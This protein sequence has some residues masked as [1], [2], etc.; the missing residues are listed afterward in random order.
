MAP[1]WLPEGLR[2]A[3]GCRGRFL[4]DLWVH[5]G[6]RLGSK[7]VPKLSR[8]LIENQA[9][10][11]NA[12]LGHLGASWGRVGADFKG[13]FGVLFRS[14]ARKPD[15]VKN[16]LPPTWEQDFHGSGGVGKAPKTCPEAVCGRRRAPRASGEAPGFDL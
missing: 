2:A 16:V 3:L 12:I 6:L 13:N 8:N 1:K 7:N 11:W 10:A 14:P 15:F 5:L 4:S 9:P